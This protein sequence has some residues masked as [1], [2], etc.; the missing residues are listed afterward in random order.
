MKN[1]VLCILIGALFTS[2]CFGDSSHIKMRYG[3][4][5]VI[6]KSSSTVL[7]APHGT[8]DINT[9][10]ILSNVCYR[11]EISCVI[12]TGFMPK[13]TRINVNRPTEG[14]G[15]MSTNEPIT[16]RATYAY[17]AFKKYVS[18]VAS[19][20]LNLYI[21]IHGSGING[22]EV[23]LHNINP[24]EAKL[25]KKILKEEWSKQGTNLI[26]IKVQGVDKIKMVGNAVKNFGIVSEL[27]PKFLA[28]EFSRPLRN[29]QDMISNFLINAIKRIDNIL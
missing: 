22:I 12:A 3:S 29:K 17:K 5:N 27:Q 23:A 11:G 24:K 14:V 19:P 7:A 8:Y 2:Y 16:A 6:N 25:I 21:E 18:S 4:F 15:I 28:F 26:P 9:G 1:K 13:G 10:A 20:N